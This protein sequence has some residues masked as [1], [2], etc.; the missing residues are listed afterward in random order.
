M[1]AGLPAWIR[2]ITP[3]VPGQWHAPHALVRAAAALAC[4]LLLP[5]TASAAPAI[6]SVAPDFALKDLEG[7]NQRLSEFRGDAVVLTFWG[8]WCGPCRGALQSMI[9]A[10]AGDSGAL[11][12]IGVSLDRDQAAGGLGLPGARRASSRHWS[13]RARRS[14]ASTT[15]SNCPTPCSSIAKG[16]CARAGHASPCPRTYCFRLSERSSLDPP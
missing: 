13:I 2:A 16:S 11:V 8:S 7:R 9:E 4:T 15:C 10:T 5:V 14:A 3:R 12:A 1:T 6:G